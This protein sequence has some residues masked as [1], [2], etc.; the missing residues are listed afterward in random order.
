MFADGARRL[1]DVRS[2]EQ[3]TGLRYTRTLYTTQGHNR[4]DKA[5]L[6][7]SD[8]RQQL[9]VKAAEDVEDLPLDWVRVDL[10]GVALQGQHDD[11]PAL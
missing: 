5:R 10:Q 1:V 11:A 2:R 6:P 8:G 3:A 7:V 4:P 9:A